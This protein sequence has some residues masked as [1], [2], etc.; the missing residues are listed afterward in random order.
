MKYS[1]AAALLLATLHA[2]LATFAQGSLTPPGAPA[3][4]MKTLDQVEA[5]RPISSA[6]FTITNSGSYYLTANLNVT[7]GDAITLSANNVTLDLNGFAIS[8]TAPSANGTGIGLGT[9]VAGI[10]ILNGHIKGGVTNNNGTYSGSG[11]AYGIIWLG[12][13]PSNVRVAG[14][15]VSGCLLDGISV[16]IGN[17]TVVESCTVAT[18]GGRGI[19]ATS[20]SQSTASDCG[21][22]AIFGDSVSDSSGL[23]NGGFGN[24]VTANVANGCHGT[25]TSG[26]GVTAIVA[27]NC[28]GYGGSGAGV[29]AN[30]ANNCYGYGGSGAGVWADT[31][32][33]CFGY[34]ASG[35]GLYVSFAASTCH[36]E[37]GESG[38]GLYSA[39]TALNSYGLSASGRGLYAE[40][41]AQ[42]C[43]GESLGAAAGLVTSIAQNCYGR[44]ATT[45]GLTFT[46]AGAMC[47]GER[48]SPP[49]SNYV[50]GSGL[51]GPVNLP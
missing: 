9:G 30:A 44:S 18:V 33:N 26:R 32:N 19:V 40:R 21:R 2:P 42:N 4:S 20:V 46:K 35:T 15:S 3:Q 17:S 13:V 11:F 41:C 6:P 34:S 7:N 38:H 29:F 39:G 25:S 8:S 24:G 14:V 5:R 49:G 31:A 27:N 1:L 47:W 48:T 51:A 12:G 28:Y 22:E 23:N 16:G 37:S 45:S 43:F 50:I 36:G 10:T